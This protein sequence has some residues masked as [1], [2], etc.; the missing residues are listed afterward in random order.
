[1]KEIVLTTKQ[2]GQ[3]DIHAIRWKGKPCWIAT[4]IA[5]AAGLR[6]PSTSVGKFLKEESYLKEGADF[7]TL[8]G[9]DLDDL[10]TVIEYYSITNSKTRN[11]TLFYETALNAFVGTRRNKTGKRL[12]QWI[13]TEVLPA[14]RERGYYDLNEATA[15]NLEEL[16]K[17]EKQVGLSKEIAAMLIPLYGKQAL[18]IY[19]LL[20]ARGFTGK[21]PKELIALAKADGVPSKVYSRGAREILPLAPL[22]GVG[23]PCER[24]WFPYVPPCMA[25]QDQPAG[26]TGRRLVVKDNLMPA[27]AHET[28]P[29]FQRLT[30]CAQ[31]LGF[32]G[33]H[34]PL[35]PRHVSNS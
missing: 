14:I 19:H 12:R 30:F 4:E 13:Y 35:Q 28:A 33:K 1:M 7:E 2:F 6:D 26:S 15:G 17:R 25:L 31:P 32:I 29:V 8:R 20:T 21:T 5:E 34:L 10:E 11:L 27:F 24:F 9:K 18:A 16:G 23:E 3:I 22:R